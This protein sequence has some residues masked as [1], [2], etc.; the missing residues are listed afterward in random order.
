M[1]KYIPIL[2]LVLLMG[3]S[4]AAVKPITIVTRQS[5]SVIN[6]E[7]PQIVKVPEPIHL[8]WVAPPPTNGVDVAYY[9]VYY[10][11]NEDMGDYTAVTV[12]NVTNTTL[13]DLPGDTHFYFR[14]TDVSTENAESDFSDQSE[15]S[16]KLE[17]DMRFIFHEPVEN[18]VV[19]GTADFVN[20]QNCPTTTV[21]GM[22]RI[23]PNRTETPMLFYRALG[24]PP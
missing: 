12:G 17:L 22:Q 2:A 20:W 14:V 7:P 13:S 10:S 4:T 11:V 23:S 18:V 15:G 9:V 1:I 6:P 24:S 16:T 3:C 8:Q 21:N 5:Q 19:Q